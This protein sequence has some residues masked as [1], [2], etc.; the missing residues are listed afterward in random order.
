MHPKLGELSCINHKL[1]AALAVAQLQAAVGVQSLLSQVRHVCTST[2]FFADKFL[3]AGLSAL[4]S[5][6]PQQQ[7]AFLVNAKV[8]PRAFC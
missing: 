7:A 6:T 8:A 4:S 1:S 5:K 3:Q 2:A